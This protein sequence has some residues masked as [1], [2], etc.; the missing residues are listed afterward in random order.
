MKRQVL[1]SRFLSWGKIVY[2]DGVDYQVAPSF[3]G[4][5]DPLI[6][7]AYFWLSTVLIGNFALVCGI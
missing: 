6:D 3:S 5:N 2:L 7:A 1:M 4:F